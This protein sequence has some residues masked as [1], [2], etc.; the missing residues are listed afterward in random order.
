VPLSLPQ[1][2]HGLTRASAVRGRRLT[3][4]AVARPL[5]GFAFA[6]SLISVSYF[7]YTNCGVT[8]CLQKELESW[9]DWLIRLTDFVAV[10]SISFYQQNRP[11]VAMWLGA[12]RGSR[13]VQSP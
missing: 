3:A 11:N 1:I 9:S 13:S 12:A 6:S 10:N 4:W 5:F 8:S 7:D 2:P